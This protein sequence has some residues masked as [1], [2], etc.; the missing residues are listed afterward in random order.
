MTSFDL[1]RVN[2]MLLKTYNKPHFSVLHVG[3]GQIS[4]RE[5]LLSI[6]EN[7]VYTGMGFMS[8]HLIG[9]VSFTCKLALS[10]CHFKSG[11]QEGDIEK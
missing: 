9:Q 11:G 4:P 7:L 2:V 3:A 10:F 8:C 6:S 1:L 5:V